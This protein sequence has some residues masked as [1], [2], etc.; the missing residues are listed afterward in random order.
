[1]KLKFKIGDRIMLDGERLSR[2]LYSEEMFNNLLTMRGSIKIVPK[3]K[4]GDEGDIDCYYCIE[5]DRQEGSTTYKSG[6]FKYWME[7]MLVRDI[8][9]R[10][11]FECITLVL[12]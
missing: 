9:I 3:L 1:M 5:W 12:I 7:Y 8:W 10:F 2:D 11:D 6:S 4:T